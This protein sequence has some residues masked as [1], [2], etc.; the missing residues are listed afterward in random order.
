MA[1]IEFSTVP[2]AK[3]LNRDERKNIQWFKSQKKPRLIGENGPGKRFETKTNHFETGDVSVKR[4]KAHGARA[5]NVGG[6]AP[7]NL[8]FAD[9][10]VNWKQEALLSALF[11]ELVQR[12]SGSANHNTWVLMNNNNCRF[13]TFNLGL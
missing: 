5:G 11:V 10:V 8:G 9:V 3:I 12:R 6:D 1:V 2:S 13:S 4:A 7:A